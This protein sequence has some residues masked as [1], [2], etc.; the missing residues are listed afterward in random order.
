MLE[1]HVDI[2][3]VQSKIAGATSIMRAKR[4]PIMTSI[5]IAKTQDYSGTAVTTWRTCSRGVL[6]NKLQ[7]LVVYRSQAYD[8][9]RRVN[10]PSTNI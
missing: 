7:M 1:Q 2:S 5:S 3:T 4:R 6:T 8:A 9:Y 10:Y